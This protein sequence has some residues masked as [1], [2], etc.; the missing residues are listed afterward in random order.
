MPL[1]WAGLEGRGRVLSTDSREVW[2]AQVQG[3]SWN[4]DPRGGST[5]RLYC[6]PPATCL[7]AS[8]RRRGSAWAC[9]PRRRG[10]SRSSAIAAC[11]TTASKCSC[12]WAAGP[13]SPPARSLSAAPVGLVCQAGASTAKGSA[14]DPRCPRS[15][16]VLHCLLGGW[17]VLRGFCCLLT[18]EA[19]GGATLPPPPHPPL[20][21]NPMGHGQRGADLWWPIGGLQGAGRP[22]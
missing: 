18:W 3:R 6:W 12:A 9:W 16:H 4:R 7:P 21:P 15:T 19:G 13:L 22:L 10:R 8:C 2:C 5:L 17:E 1:R 14:G 20:Q 11:C